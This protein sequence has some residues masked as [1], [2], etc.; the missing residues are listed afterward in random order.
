[1][2]KLARMMKNRKGFTLVELMV[3]VVII[4]IL[5]AIAIPLYNSTQDNARNRAC[6]ANLRTIDGAI[7]QYQANDSTSTPPT[8]VAQLV[9]G[10]YLR[11]N[12]VCPEGEVGP[13]TIT[14]GRTYCPVS[15]SGHT[16]PTS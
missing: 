12:P 13:Y 3:V 11:H 7:A 1:M 14:S 9:A 15:G 16:L 5:V 6:Q 8:S 4:G 10:G 2:M